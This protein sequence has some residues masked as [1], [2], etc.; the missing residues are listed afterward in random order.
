MNDA[1]QQFIGGVVYVYQPTQVMHT[2]NAMYKQVNLNQPRFNDA[3]R[4]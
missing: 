1:I 3:I 2:H 4:V